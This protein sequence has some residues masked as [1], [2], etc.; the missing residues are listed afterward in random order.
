MPPEVTVNSRNQEDGDLDTTF[1]YSSLTRNVRQADNIKGK[2]ADEEEY[3]QLKQVS[4]L[5][6]AC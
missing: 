3:S 4:L 2:I 5:L 1:F 6:M